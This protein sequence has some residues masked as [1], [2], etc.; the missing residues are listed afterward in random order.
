MGNKFYTKIDMSSDTLGTV[1][2]CFRL[3]CLNLDIK[4]LVAC[5]ANQTVINGAFEVQL[6]VTTAFLI[7]GK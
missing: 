4:V 1:S 7:P 3:F 6:H 2:T 5:V